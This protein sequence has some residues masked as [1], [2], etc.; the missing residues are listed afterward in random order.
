MITNQSAQNINVPPERG[1]Y[2]NRTLNLNSIRAIGY[3]MD[4]TLVHY[5]T[6][7]WERAA[8]DHMKLKLLEQDLPVED[9]EFDPNL[10]MRGLT[11]DVELGNLLKTNRFNFV[12]QAAHG[13]RE[14]AFEEL[15]Q[16]YA[17]VSADLGD[18]RFRFLNTLFSMSEG[19]MYAQLVDKMDGGELPEGMGYADLAHVVHRSIDEA[20]MEGK[21]KAEILADPERFIVRDPD[22]PIALLDQRSAGKK[23]LLI[24]NS[25][26]YYTSK[27]LTLIADPF[28]PHGKTWRDLFDIVIVAARKPTFFERRE[29]AFEIIN[30]EGHLK[31]ARGPLETGKCYVGA[32]A[33]LVEESLGCSG[34]E[35]LYMGD[36]LFADVHVT[37][38]VMRWR[39]GLVVRELEEELAAL[40]SF[41]DKQAHLGRAMKQKAALEKQLNQL[42]LFQARHRENYGDD[43][44]MSL[45]ELRTKK[46]ALWAELKALDD[47][48]APLAQE[49]SRLMHPRWGLLMR[50]GNDK[51]QYARQLEQYSDIYLSRISNFLY[52]TPFAYIRSTYSS[53][54]HDTGEGEK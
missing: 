30:E 43:G 29:P 41:R 52:A 10:I 37:K 49:A 1:I 38:N 25:E 46:D 31:P 35:L 47:T 26:W 22:M 15:R 53:L 32:C 14:L 21:L 28:L 13:T 20:H 24:T 45:D 39:T 16:T 6:E 18:E 23:L 17:R 40:E 54:P 7:E 5:N 36:H 2:C 34:E 12:K 3:D 4:Y 42:R 33:S 11:I 8:F 19:C 44:G 50:S 9:L 27:I 48:I 51:S